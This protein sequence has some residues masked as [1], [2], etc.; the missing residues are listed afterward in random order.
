M[1]RH[2]QVDW[3]YVYQF[4]VDSE[5]LYSKQVY[6]QG[7]IN[8]T[9]YRKSPLTPIPNFKLSMISRLIMVGFSVLSNIQQFMLVYNSWPPPY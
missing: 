3:V 5:A 4:H 2:G 6:Q 8:N 1:A 7:Y 9:P